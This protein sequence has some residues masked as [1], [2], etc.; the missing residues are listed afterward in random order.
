MFP[1]T[2]WSILADAT[3]NGDTAGRE[4]L[5]QLCGAYR[6]PVVAYLRTRGWRE[7]EA[8]DLAQE[9]FLRLLESRAWRRAQRQRGRFRTFLLGA[10]THVVQHQLER[11]GAAKRG[12][13]LVASLD[14]MAEDGFEA[15][16]VPA[17]A[18]SFDREWARR[19][20]EEAVL[21]VEERFR[22][23]G[24]A[25]QFAVLRQYLP[26]A[27]EPPVYE[28][29]AARLSVSVANLKSAIHRLRLEFRA[30][31]RESVARTVSAPHEVDEEL[32]HLRQVLAQEV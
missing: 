25:A 7:E 2:D 32:R 15:P 18:E 29:A 20:V 14:A 28:E 30:S 3:L 9:F 17:H 11:E 22:G 27:A 26:G 4:A 16:A 21:S 24:R 5:S 1:N 6:P 12:K 23:E 13:A 8:E 10:V 19:L 31:L